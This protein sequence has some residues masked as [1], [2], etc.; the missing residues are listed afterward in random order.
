MGRTGLR[1][2]AREPLVFRIDS[3]EHVGRAHFPAE[4]STL[5]GLPV[6][7]SRHSAKLSPFCKSPALGGLPYPWLPAA[8]SMHQEA[9]GFPWV[10]SL[11][12][13]FRASH[14]S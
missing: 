12:K 3:L 7:T 11:Q 10:M 2:I 5:I 4:R 9:E 1:V 8:P 6:K 14:L 13:L